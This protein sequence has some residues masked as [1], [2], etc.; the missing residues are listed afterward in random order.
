MK[1]EIVKFDDQL[2]GGKYQ[3]RETSFDAFCGAIKKDLTKY[4]DFVSYGDT[5]KIYRQKDYDLIRR[6]FDMLYSF[7]ILHGFA[8]ISTN[9]GLFFSEIWE[10][11]GCDYVL[12]QFHCVPVDEFLALLDTKPSLDARKK[13]DKVEQYFCSID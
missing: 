7:R 3:K 8:G 2:V 6:S 10:R 11:T 13:V 9:G 12:R 1:I 4:H 5:R